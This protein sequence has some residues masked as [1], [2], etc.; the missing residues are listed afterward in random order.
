M[1]SP[2]FLCIHSNFAGKNVLGPSRRSI[3]RASTDGAEGDLLQSSIIIAL[4]GA[5]FLQST[6]F[7]DR[8]VGLVVK[9]S[10][11]R[12]EGPEFESPSRRDVFGVE[13]YQ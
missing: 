1:G 9:A 2:L 13:S 5:D 3:N 8:L 7:A 12:A 10:A 6:H 11:S 4:R